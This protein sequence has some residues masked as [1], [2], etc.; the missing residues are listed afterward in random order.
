[1]KIKIRSHDAQM[2]QDNDWRQ[3]GDWLTTLRDDDHADPM[4]D[5]YAEPARADHVSQEVHGETYRGVAAARAEAEARAEAAYRAE[6]LYRAQAA[7]S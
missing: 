6:A 7:A 4:S 3:T 5:G 1:M 2:L